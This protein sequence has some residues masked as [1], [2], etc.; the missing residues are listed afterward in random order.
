MPEPVIN[1]GRSTD[2]RRQHSEEQS[3]PPQKGSTAPEYAP[4]ARETR[5]SL[6]TKPLL[7][8]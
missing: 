4:N 6:D 7:Y 2:R 5:R 3:L 8:Q 1:D